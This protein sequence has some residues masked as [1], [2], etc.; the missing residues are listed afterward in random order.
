MFRYL[1]GNL[2]RNIGMRV[3]KLFDIFLLDRVE[4]CA[5]FEQGGDDLGALGFGCDP[6]PYL[7]GGNHDSGIALPEESAHIRPIALGNTEF[8][9]QL[10]GRTPAAS[11]GWTV[12]RHAG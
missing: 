3:Q 5:N 9:H 7:G 8:A 10:K 6:E 12:E 2:A 4:S 11:R 1:Q